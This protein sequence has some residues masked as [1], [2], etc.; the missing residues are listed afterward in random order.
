[1]HPCIGMLPM[2]VTFFYLLICIH[3][4]GSHSWVVTMSMAFCIHCIWF[5]MVDF[6][7]TALFGSTG[8]HY[9]SVRYSYIIVIIGFHREKG[10]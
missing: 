8:S 5:H 7:M 1:M 3:I 6:V 4:G 10:D 9:I 2:L